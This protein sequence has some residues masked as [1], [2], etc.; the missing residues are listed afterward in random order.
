[1][2]AG[3]SVVGPQLDQLGGSGLLYAGGAGLRFRLSKEFPL[4]FSVDTSLNKRGDVYTYIYIGQS[5]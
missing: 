3:A 2:F 1:M 5:F 4:D